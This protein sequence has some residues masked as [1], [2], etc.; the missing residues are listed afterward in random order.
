MSIS[1]RHIKTCLRNAIRKGWGWYIYDNLVRWRSWKLLY[2]N[3]PGATTL[4]GNWFNHFCIQSVHSS[5]GNSLV[6][7][8]LSCICWF[9]C[10]QSAVSDRLLY[11]PGQASNHQMTVRSYF[12]VPGET[13]QI[14]WNLK[15]RTRAP[16]IIKLVLQDTP[17]WAKW[18]PNR[19]LKSF[20]ESKH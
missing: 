13:L 16:Q 12:W 15:A 9:A 6:A 1:N 7:L 18:N 17:K 14:Q 3:L 10:L 8:A 4:R 20:I 5:I 19:A 2:Q 11:H